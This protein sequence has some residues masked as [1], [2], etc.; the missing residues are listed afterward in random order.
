[1][2]WSYSDQEIFS[3]EELV[4]L[5]NLSA[6]NSSPAKF[7]EELINFYNNYYLNL[8]DVKNLYELIDTEYEVSFN[9]K[10]NDKYLDILNLVREGAKTVLDLIDQIKFFYEVP[11]YEEQ[12]KELITSNIEAVK[13]F[14]ENI[15]NIDFNNQQNLENDLKSFLSSKNLKFPQLGKPLRLILSGRQNAPSI[16]QLLFFLG[17]EESLK[18]INFFLD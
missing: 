18:R 3:K 1:L 10:S 17:E 5:F 11:C 13:I 15:E 9:I 4:S 12:H 2:G 14:S 6:V 8:L 16:S 7:S